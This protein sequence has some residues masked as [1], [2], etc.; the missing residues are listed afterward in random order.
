MCAEKTFLHRYFIAHFIAVAF[1]SAVLAFPVLNRWRL[2]VAKEV[3]MRRDELLKPDLL[4]ELLLLG[5]GVAIIV[6][7]VIVVVAA[8]VASA[9]MPQ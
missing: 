4:S 5:G 2:R 6:A 3:G 1:I 9:A 8:V 7:L